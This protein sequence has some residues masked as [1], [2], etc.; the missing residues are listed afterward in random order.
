MAPLQYAM[1][2]INCLFPPSADPE[3]GAGGSDRG[4]HRHHHQAVS[5]PPQEQPGPALQTE[6][7][8]TLDLKKYFL[9]TFI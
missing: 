1:H 2:S 9:L 6:G 3:A 5:R 8:E 7:A 4:G